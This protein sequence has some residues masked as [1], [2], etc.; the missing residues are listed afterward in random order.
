MK[1]SPAT[2][3]VNQLLSS[4]SEQYS[5]PPYQRRHSWGERGIWELID[6]AELLEEGANCWEALSASRE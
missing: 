2:L 6:D 4:P 5:I 3:S 1:I